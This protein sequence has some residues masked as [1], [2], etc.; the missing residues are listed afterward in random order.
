LRR[1]RH[2]IAPAEARAFVQAIRDELVELDGQRGVID[3]RAF[4][5]EFRAIVGRAFDMDRAARLAG[6]AVL[7]GARPDQVQEYQRLYAAW[8]VESFRKYFV[9]GVSSRISIFS[10]EAVAGTGDAYVKMV[11]PDAVPPVLLGARV[12]RVDG[13]AKIID[14]ARGGISLMK[15]QRDE[16][17]AVTQARGM[18]GLLAELRSRVGTVTALGTS[19]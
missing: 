17:A 18:D 13:A 12:R 9:A 8:M 6:G 2:D 19:P 1:P 15:T 5:A 11:L 10:S 14:F 7:A 16:F 4:A 3:R